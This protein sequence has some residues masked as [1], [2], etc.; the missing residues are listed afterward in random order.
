VKAC[1]LVGFV[2]VQASEALHVAAPVEDHFSVALRPAGTDTGGET[3]RVTT[4]GLAVAACEKGTASAPATKALARANRLER[5]SGRAIAS[6]VTS[7][8]TVA[9]TASR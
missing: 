9:P 6:D 5:R 7:K 4:G 8:P 1:P 2:P 3:V